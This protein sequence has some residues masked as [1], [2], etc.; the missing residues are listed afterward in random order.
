MLHV[1]TGL[2]SGGAERTLARLL[3]SGP[4]NGT[5]PL[6]AALRP[7]GHFRER[8]EASGGRVVELGV[9]SPFSALPGLLR[10]ANLIRRERPN[11]IQT[12]MYHADLFGLLALRLSGRRRETR[13]YWGIRCSDMNLSHYSLTLRLVIAGCRR[14]SGRVDGIIANSEAGLRIHRALGYRNAKLAVIDNGLDP[15]R[16]RKSWETRA[17]MRRTLGLDADAF[18]AGVVARN[19]PMKGYP[20]MLDAIDATPGFVWVA[21]GSGTERLPERDGLVRLGQREDVPELLAAMDVLVSTS[22]F[23]EGFSNAI[24]EAMATGLPVVATD[25]GDARRIVGEAG[26]IVPPRDAEAVAD[27]V[28]RLRNEPGFA[29]R[30]GEAG[31][32]RVAER[33]SVDAMR[34]QFARVFAGDPA[35]WSAH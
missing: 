11:V 24:L 15:G 35:P 14:L 33:F 31:R 18:V 23:G 28:R 13:I 30:L 17:A 19:D 22:W 7:G 20:T 3:A 1:I 6:V 21:I 34:R 12:W 8:I 10:L 25:V 32:R 4:E 26:V 2:G 5:R 29:R 16:Y 9:R 27:A